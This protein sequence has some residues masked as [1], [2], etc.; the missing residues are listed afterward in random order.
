MKIAVAIFRAMIALLMF[1]PLFA[2]RSEAQPTVA[3]SADVRDHSQSVLFTF[4]QSDVPSMDG[5]HY[6]LFA[7]DKAADLQ[8]LPG[9]GLSIATFYRDLST[10]QIIAGP[11]PHL[12]RNAISGKPLSRRTVKVYFRVLLSCPDAI[13]G[14]GDVISVSIKTF[15]RGTLKSINKLTLRM[16]HNMRYY[17]P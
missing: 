11:L 4:A 10:I 6:N 7:A 12:A 16:K 2:G 3:L 1:V 13:D 5:C 8:T 9:K 17:E 15:P 14:L